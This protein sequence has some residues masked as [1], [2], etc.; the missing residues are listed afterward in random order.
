MKF[1][2]PRRGI[3]GM[4]LALAWAVPAARAEDAPRER[5]T[6][7]PLWLPQAQFAGYYLALEKGFYARRG[8]DVDVLRGGPEHDVVEELETG[9]V[10]FAIVW[11]AQALF[12][13]DRGVPLTHVAQVFATSNLDIV[14]WRKKGVATLRDLDGRRVS[15]WGDSLRPPF[16]AFFRSQNVKPVIVPQ[17]ATIN[18]FLLG[19][20]DACSVMEYNEYHSIF[21]AGVD[22]SELVRFQLGKYGVD[23]PED[24]LYGLRKTREARPHVAKALAEASL[25]GWKYAAEHV[26]EALDSVMK[27]TRE[28]NLP[29]NRVHMRWMLRVVLRSVFPD[30]PAGSGAPT[31]PDRTPGRLSRRAYDD[32]VRRLLELGALKRAPT[33]EEFTR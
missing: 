3:L 2:R 28:A 19:G 29:V 31:D 6:L 15:V 13:V 27:R 1:D 30:G 24:G 21:L 5:V 32:T 26:E 11:L 33:Y 16:E 20:V 14:A 10:D 7:L 12:A 17:H 4:L 23:F 9:K 8:L 22:E 18:L 25:E